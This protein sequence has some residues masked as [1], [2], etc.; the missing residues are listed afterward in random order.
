MG[1]VMAR[2]LNF[3]YAKEFIKKKYGDETFTR[4]LDRLPQEVKGIWEDA[5]LTDSYPFSAFKAM[6]AALS[7][8]LGALENREIA[9]MYEYIADRSLNVLYKMF[10]RMTNPSFVISNY[11]KLWRRF[12]ESG[13]V[14]VPLSEKGYARVRFLLPEIFLDWLPPACLGY[15]KKA[16][17]MAGGKNLMIKLENKSLS[18]ENVWDIVYQLRWE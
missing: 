12:F 11:P 3:V 1:E 7:G 13:T 2:G 14:E 17:E 9:K 6:T 8:E 16:V 10:F 18:S 15:S 4:L 5:V